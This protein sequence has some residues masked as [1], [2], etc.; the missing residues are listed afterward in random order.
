[1]MANMGPVLPKW[2]KKLNKKL[3]KKLKKLEQKYDSAGPLRKDRIMR[4]AESIQNKV[5]KD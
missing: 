3:K 1:M 4:Q 5:E 2:E